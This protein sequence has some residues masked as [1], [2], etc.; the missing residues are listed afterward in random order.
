MA[1]YEH[2]ENL[3]L[4]K[5]LNALKESL[6]PDVISSQTEFFVKVAQVAAVLGGLFGFLIGIVG[7]VKTDS[8]VLFGAGVGWII[9]VVFL[10]YAGAVNLDAC[11]DAIRNSPTKISTFRILDAFASLVGLTI[12]FSL[13]GVLYVVIKFE[14]F[15]IL[16]FAIPILI[17][18]FYFMYILLFPSEISTTEN[19]SVSAGNDALTIF[20]VLAKASLRLVPITFGT[21]T[22]V[23]AYALGYILYGFFGEDGQQK[24]FELMSSGFTALLGA[25]A[26]LYGLL[27]PLVTYVFFVIFFLAIDLARNILTINQV[28]TGLTSRNDESS[29][30]SYS[31][32][33]RADPSQDRMFHVS[34]DVSG[35]DVRFV[36]ETELHAMYRS[37]VITRDTLIWTDGAAEWMPY[38]S[39]FKT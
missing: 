39:Y 25:A 36:T 12:I 20:S 33:E 8:F 34:I 24:I 16:K 23:G 9:L 27:Y 11:S 4:Q 2:G 17:S 30:Q 21:L 18:L 26:F 29:Q 22:A 38:G 5:A 19:P 1:G 7:A 37:G 6:G 32:S 3:I 10:Y 13:V 35:S 28:S 14:N 15:E 31:A